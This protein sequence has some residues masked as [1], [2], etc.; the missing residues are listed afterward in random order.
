MKRRA[1][2]ATALE[3]VGA[4]NSMSGEPGTSWAMPVM[5][6]QA[7]SPA[8]RL[9]L[10][11]V[12]KAS[13]LDLGGPPATVTPE[14]AL[15]ALLGADSEYGDD[16]L[17]SAGG[18]AQYSVGKV[19]LPKDQTVSAS[20]EAILEGLPRKQVES[21]ASHMLLSDEEYQG[22][23]E[24][25]VPPTYMDPIL[26][27]DRKN[28]LAFLRELK[29]CGI[30]NLVHSLFRFEERQSLE[31]NTR[32]QEIQPVFPSTAWRSQFQSGVAQHY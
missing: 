20:L 22:E 6:G 17:G 16:A 19:S 15:Q 11:R 18:L 10:D 1:R 2:Q 28:Y 27:H 3:C 9:V 32:R 5:G 14:A 12:W 24:K 29:D 7:P 13:A 31:I 21:C 25:G 4:L 30:I 8:Q 23:C 26:E